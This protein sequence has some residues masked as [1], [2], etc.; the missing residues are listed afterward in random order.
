MVELGWT[1][2][3]VTQEHLENLMRKGY[4]TVAELA[5]YHV[6]EDPAPPALVGGYIVSCT[7]FYE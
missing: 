3:E 7:V 4:M 6:F 2:S 1:V 5:T